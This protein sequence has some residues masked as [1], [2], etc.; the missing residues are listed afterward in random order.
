[1]NASAPPLDILI[2]EDEPSDVFLVRRILRKA[3]MRTE[4]RHCID[5]IAALELLEDAT[6][7]PQP[8]LILLDINMPRM[9]GH[10]F[11]ARLRS[12]PQGGNIPVIMLSTSSSE[13]DMSRAMELGADAYVTKQA[14]LAAFGA[15]L[16]GALRRHGGRSLTGEDGTEQQNQQLRIL[17]VDGAPSDARQVRQILD[18][19]WPGSFDLRQAGSISEVANQLCH[20][21]PGIILLDFKLPDSTGPD[22]V[23]RLRTLAGRTPIVVLTGDDDD[24]TAV[25][26]LEAGAQD[27]LVKMP[28]SPRELVRAM[29]HA[30]AR[31][32]LEER[33]AESEERMSLAL[34]GAELGLWD[35]NIPDG[36]LTIDRRWAGMVGEDEGVREVGGDGWLAR[37]HPEDLGAALSSLHDHFRGN[38]PGFRFAHRLRHRDGH[39]VWTQAAG[40]V[41]QRQPDGTPLRAVGT[42][43]DVGDTKRLEAD[44]LRLA[45][46]DSLTGLDNRR[47][48]LQKLE[49][50]L[51]RLRRRPDTTSA[52][53]MIDLDHFKAINDAWGHQ[54]GDEALRHFADTLR[55]TQRESDVCGRLGGEEFAVMLPDTGAHAALQ[56]ARRLRDRLAR[57]PLSPTGRSLPIRISVGITELRAADDTTE[58]C[59]SRADEA[60]Y[61]AKRQ[62]R[63]R[64]VCYEDQH[65]R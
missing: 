47:V 15:G 30:L 5:G 61:H 27:Y 43:Q 54:V 22:T 31:A 32:R 4:L 2:V 46:T 57:S 51:A 10:E 33:V 36:L 63:D 42:M 37:V 21:Q 29:R 65:R 49:H 1:M 9:N 23:E 25:R 34:A 6:A 56:F 26:A 3:G 52:L 16:L 60:L 35:W 58:S 39:W 12:H 62:G 19:H 48:F 41:L 11:L 14:D 40:K 50:E 59:I 38:T 28:A 45:T 18:A 44:L 53:L 20:W 64:E 7:R 13:H 17:L 55:N 24:E 8:Q